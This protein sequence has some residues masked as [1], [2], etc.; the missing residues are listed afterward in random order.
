MIT[1][2]IC[3][4]ESSVVNQLE[5]ILTEVLETL[6]I[7]Y[8]MD[9]HVSGESLMQSMESGAQYD[10]LFLDIEFA[11]D[12][13]NGIDV[14]KQLRERQ[15]DDRTAIV[16]IS[17]HKKYA[18]ELFNVRPWHFLVKPL[19]S[20]KIEQTI[21]SYLDLS[22]RRTNYFTYKIGHAAHKAQIKDILYLESSGKKLVLHLTNGRKPE[23]YG[24]IRAEY[25][26]QLTQF[27]FLFI[28]SSFVANFDY[29]ASLRGNELILM[30]GDILPISQHR[31]KGIGARY[32]AIMERRQAK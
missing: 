26:A 8:E 23:F 12:K 27:D 17:W 25:Q 1:V 15:Q 24:S 14:G 7:Q 32:L 18:M 11:K 6:Q 16:Y 4:D 31:R 10:I 20:V 9:V 2:A 3:D 13:L 5:S 30:N 19:D 21:R 22:G 28:H 29:V